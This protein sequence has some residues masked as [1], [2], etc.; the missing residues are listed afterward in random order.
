M[1]TIFA[2]IK[3]FVD[4]PFSEDMPATHWFAFVGLLLIIVMFW[5]MILRA[6]LGD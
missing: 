6:L 5:H 2:D 4:E 1:G 3:A